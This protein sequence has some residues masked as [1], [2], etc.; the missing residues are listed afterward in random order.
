MPKN[1]NNYPSEII[2][3]GQKIVSYISLK[4]NYK[5]ERKAMRFFGRS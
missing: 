1:Q 4:S 3:F 5:I 2:Y